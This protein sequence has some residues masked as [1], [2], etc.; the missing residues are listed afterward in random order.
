M[1]LMDRQETVLHIPSVNQHSVHGIKNEW[2][3]IQS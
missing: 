3:L 2:K 1:H